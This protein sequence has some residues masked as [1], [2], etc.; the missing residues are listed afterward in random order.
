MAGRARDAL[1][2]EEIEVLADRGYFK[3]EEL[4]ACE[5]VGIEAYV[6]SR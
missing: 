5:E 4:A 6:P 3:S 2:A 1:E